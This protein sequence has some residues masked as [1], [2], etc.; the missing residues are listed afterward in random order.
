M[1]GYLGHISKNSINDIDYNKTNEQ[2]ICRGPD[3]KKEIIKNKNHERDLLSYCLIFNRLAIIDLSDLASQPMSSK[4]FGTELVFNGEIFNHA[5]LREQ[6]QKKGIKFFSNHSDTEVVLNG[7]SYYGKKFLSKMIGQ[8]SLVFIDNKDGNILMARDRLGQKPLFYSFNNSD[9][10][11]ASNLQVVSDISKNTDVDFSSINQYL[12]F[13]VVPA[14]KTI[15]KN[16]FKMLPGEVV[17]FNFKNPELKPAS[18]FYWS[19]LDHVEDKK[20]E[21]DVFEDLLNDSLKIR[22]EA[23]V[24]IATFLSGGIDSTSIVKRQLDIG[25]SPNTF[26]VGYQDSKYD[27][28]K[29]FNLVAEKYNTNHVVVNLKNKIETQDIFSAIESLDE[30]YSDPSILPSFLISREISKYYKVAISGDGGDELFGGYKRTQLTLNRN[31]MPFSDM[32]FKLYPSFLG[33]GSLIKSRSKNMKKAYSSFLEDEKLMKLLGHN[34]ENRFDLY[35]EN[36]ENENISDFKNLLLSDYKFY[37][38]EMMMLKIDRTSMANS[39]EVRSPYVDH[40]LIEYILG[41]DTKTTENFL[42]KKYLKN[43]LKT[44]FEDNFLNREKMGFVFNVENFIYSNKTFVIDLLIKSDFLNNRKFQKLFYYKSRIN[45]NRL[46][47]LLT[48]EIF[49]NKKEN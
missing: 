26:S 20:F 13:N 11:F 29:W 12:K 18:E 49:L 31:I 10:F 27:E 9:L 1:C 45:A 22:M 35:F 19:P 33:T 37:L 25:I 17:E 38:P 34:N 39:L 14:P 42:G 28:S 21:Q 6:L 30:P 36:Q 24:P 16:I 3:E 5:E 47:K 15:Y 7:L 32:L 41:H 44:D 48:L 23:D 40:R 8:F 2:L 4:E 43:Y 46:W